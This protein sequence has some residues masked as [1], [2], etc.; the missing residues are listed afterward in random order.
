M[1]DGS[2]DH[3]PLGKCAVIGSQLK[4]MCTGHIHHLLAY[5]G[6]AVKLKTK[7]KDEAEGGNYWLVYK[8]IVMNNGCIMVE[9]L[10]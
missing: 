9:L 4:R 2:E 1:Q 8:S 3:C 5:L 10:K 7:F 6:I